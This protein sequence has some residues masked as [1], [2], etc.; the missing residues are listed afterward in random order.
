MSG[1]GR[2]PLHH[3]LTT[4][5]HAS[6]QTNDRVP[7]TKAPKDTDTPPSPS[8]EPAPFDKHTEDL[9]DP[10]GASRVTGEQAVNAK[11]A[12]PRLDLPVATPNGRVSRACHNCRKQKNKCSG[13]QPSCLR[14]QETNVACVYVDGKRER[15]A[16]C[17]FASYCWIPIGHRIFTRVIDISLL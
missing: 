15:N 1:S 12:I 16:K 17:V 7:I 2:P 5:L 11:V 10:R 6:I 4:K 13:H 3:L 9:I 8:S 14:C